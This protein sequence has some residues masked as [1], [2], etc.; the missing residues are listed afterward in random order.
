M[1]EGA[2]VIAI[3]RRCGF[4]CP[5]HERT[6]FDSGQLKPTRLERVVERWKA[7]GRLKLG[8]VGTDPEPLLNYM[9]EEEMAN[10]ELPRDA[11]GREIPLDT[12]ILY[13][14]D[15][16]EYEVYYYK[17]SVRQTLPQH[18]WQVVMTDYIVHDCSDIYIAQ[19]D[20]WEKL[21]EDLHAVEV[22][23][24]SPDLEDP[25]CAYAHNIGKKCAECKLYAGDCTVNMCKDI[26][27]RINK[28]R[29]ESK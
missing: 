28:L 19:P 22:R 3:Y 18:K 24:D 21:D 12:K 16:N 14:E 26:A 7:I 15:E 25:V 11:E 17:Y 4:D 13:D 20:S 9:M 5:Y 23:G 6:R 2:E 29:S 10:I 1:D 27:S 8:S